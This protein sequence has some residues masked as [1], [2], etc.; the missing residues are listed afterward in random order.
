MT[1]IVYITETQSDYKI[2]GL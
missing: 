1:F 2:G